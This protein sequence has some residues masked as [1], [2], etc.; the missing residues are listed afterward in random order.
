VQY[1]GFLHSTMQYS[2]VLYSTVQHNTMSLWRPYLR[3]VEPHDAHGQDEGVHLGSLFVGAPLVLAAEAALGGGGHLGEAL[4]Q[5]GEVAVLA[6]LQG[7]GGQGGTGGIRENW[8]GCGACSSGQRGTKQ[9]GTGGS[10]RL[11]AW[12]PGCGAWMH[13]QQQCK[14]TPQAYND[15]RGHKKQPGHSRFFFF[16]FPFYKSKETYQQDV[17]VGVGE[18]G[19]A[20]PRRSWRWSSRT[21]AAAGQ[22]RLQEQ[23]QW[24]HTGGGTALK[25]ESGQGHEQANAVEK[26]STVQYRTVQ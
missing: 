1:S 5:A 10:G 8:R 2:T 6:R 14:G 13:A 4:R 11:T 25:H 19:Q 21:G 3:L 23:E 15:T 7:E 16:F 18:V 22:A 9:G 12:Q 26:E 20:C 24:D 17:G